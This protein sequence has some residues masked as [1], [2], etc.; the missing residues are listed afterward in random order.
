VFTNQTPSI[1]V[2]GLSVGATTLA[3]SQIPSHSHNVLY[4]DGE[5]NNNYPLRSAGMRVPDASLNSSTDGAG[6]GGSHTHSISGSA[7]SSAITLNVRY[8]NVIICSKN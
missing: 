8:A 6:G 3:T 5:Q 4:W 2:S 7:T 1:N